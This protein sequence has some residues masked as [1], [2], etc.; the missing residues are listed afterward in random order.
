MK[1]AALRATDERQRDI[2]DHFKG[3][4]Y[5]YDRR[6]GYWKDQGKE[7]VKI[8]SLNEI[9]QAMATLVLHRPDD[10]R[11]R[12]GDYIKE[13]KKGDEQYKQIFGAS[14]NIPARFLYFSSAC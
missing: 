8:V 12:P 7:I 6:P 13:G 11:A 9:I 3:H 4:D 5:Y 1:A 14:R 10:A 2:E